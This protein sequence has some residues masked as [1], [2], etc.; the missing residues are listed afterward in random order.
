[1]KFRSNRS[2]SHSLIEMMEPRQLLHSVPSLVEVP[3]SSSAI[4]ADPALSN[5][6][7]F[8]LKEDT[9]DDD[10]ISGGLRIILTKG[11]F[12]IPSTGDSNTPQ[13]NLWS[14]SPNLQ[15]DTFVSAPG[16]SAPI[17]LGPHTGSGSAVFSAT[18]MNV[19]WGDL[20]DTGVGVS[21]VAR[22]TISTDAVGSLVGQISNSSA[23]T[24][25]V[26]FSSAL[27]LI[28]GGAAV[29]GYVWNDLD[30]DGGK[31]GAETKMASV[32]VYVDSTLR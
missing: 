12:Y 1:M 23:P 8:D 17:I 22:F 2:S 7:C 10:W 32:Q 4:A 3:I 24:S 5:F 14:T 13:S 30:G 15:F 31:N 11:S 29:T 20:T 16:F 25:P 21:T 9:L 27:P 6:R 19:D 18:E 28:A 26:D